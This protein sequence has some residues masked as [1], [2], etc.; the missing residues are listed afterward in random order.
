MRTRRGLAFLPIALLGTLLSANAAAQSADVKQGE[1]SVQRFEPAAGSKNFLSVE[2]A[3]MD[4]QMGWTVG[5]MFNYAHKPFVVRSC[6]SQTD[7][8]NPNA[9]NEQD[10]VVIS[11]MYWGDVMASLSPI[12]RLQ[13]GIRVP[14]AFV[15]GDGLD[16]ETGGT[17]GG[18]QK[19]GVGD[20]NIEAKLR[21]IGEPKD[22]AV[23]AIAGDVS[24]PVG[25]YAFGAP[26]RDTTK[27]EVEEQ[28]AYIGNQSPVT[29]GLRLIVDGNYKDFLTF[30]VNLRGVLRQDARLASTTVGPVDFRY[31]AGIGIR[32]TPIFRILAEGYGSTQF[33]DR[34]GTNALEV[35]GAVQ[36]APLDTG[37]TIT[38][39]GGAGVIEGVGV[40]V[41]RALVGVMYAHEIGDQDADGI[42]DRK[43]QCP[44]IKEDFDKFED[45]DGCP[46]DDNDGDKI[47]DTTDKCPL[48][49]ENLNGL[50]DKDGCPD[51]L[52][53]KDKD[54][55]QDGDDKCPDEVGGEPK[56]VLRAPGTN[57][58]C[59]DSDQDGVPDKTD[60][61]KDQAED[62]DGFS[63]TDGCPDPDNDNDGII[64]DND[65]CID[66]PEI[67]NGFQDTDG[68]PDSVPDKDGDGLPDNVDK[69]P[70]VPE[71]VNGFEDDDG[72]PDK[73]PELVKIGTDD[74]KILQ[75]VEFATGKDAIQGAPS[76]AVLDA[77]ASALKLHPEIFLVE[78]SGHT[79]NVGVAA[80]NKALS[81]K[82]AE[83]VVKYIV[84]KGIDA[85]R[86]QAKGY[87]AEKPIADN[88]TKAGQQKNRRVEFTILKSTKKT[89]V[90][91]VAQPAAPAPAPAPTP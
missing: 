55:I 67:K 77:V 37:I 51:E 24:A 71:N 70:S 22:L 12:S 58:G 19:F 31:G 66:Q 44:T 54:G 33:S 36:L 85:N 25:G 79:D 81:Q 11:D 83:A 49:P 8:S 87:G 34:S 14:V 40:P 84:G 76:F 32:P 59:L 30:G 26:D 91:S 6:V 10:T 38:A 64:D 82:R 75:R 3:R 53:D 73:G 72:C 23:L 90:G 56:K 43:D 69:C 62:T 7:C 41:A 2:T 18:L 39:G 74:I 57:Y 60:Q 89:A 16:F 48:K 68:C 15:N 63:D 61:C 46:E 52:P 80:D 20:I 4:G 17:A 42:D 5:L 78:V 88:K 27:G 65:E 29:G 13:L 35:L 45:D 28:G 86:L 47:P 50:D 1:F 9:I 21:I